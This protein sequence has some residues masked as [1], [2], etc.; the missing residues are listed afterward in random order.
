MNLNDLALMRATPY[1]LQN[2]ILICEDDKE[3]IVEIIKSLVYECQKRKIAITGGETSIHNNMEG[4]D[5]S[6]TVSG[7]IKKI[8]PNKF[9]KGDIL[10]GLKSNGLHSNGFTKVREIYK[11]DFRPEFV[12][13]T[14]IY[15]DTMVNLEEKFDIGGMMHITGGAYTKLKDLLGD[16]DASVRND[17]ELQ[18]QL[19][20][21]DLYKKGISDEEMYKT[22]NCGIG[23][24]FSV[25]PKDAKEI[26]SEIEEADIIGK[27][28]SGS[29]KVKV[30]SAFSKRRIEY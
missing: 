15:L 29:G 23:F 1:R 30:K 22:F 2:H 13:P 9:R 10:I 28:V 16:T 11:D 21:R 20:F 25:L 3:A 4:L 8:K 6:V 5:I 19:I 14:R 26:I 12:E 17:H 7:F 27:I 24:I 18:P